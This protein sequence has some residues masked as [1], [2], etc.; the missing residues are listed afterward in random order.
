MANTYAAAS[1]T[2]EAVTVQGE[3]PAQKPEA[4]KQ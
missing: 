2:K 3:A 4:N 1:G